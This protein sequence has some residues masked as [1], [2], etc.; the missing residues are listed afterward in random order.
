MEWWGS[1]SMEER[2]LE[3]FSVHKGV[4]VKVRGQDPEGVGRNSLTGTMKSNGFYPWELGEEKER[5]RK[6][7]KGFSC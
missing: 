3:T 6:F 1:R 4:S 7:P 2:I 5:P